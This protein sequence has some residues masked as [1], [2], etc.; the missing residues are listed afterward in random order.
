M[1]IES[2]NKVKEQQKQPLTTFILN[3]IYSFWMTNFENWIVVV[4]NP[5]NSVQLSIFLE[6]IPQEKWSA[7]TNGCK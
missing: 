2:N 7:T 6:I 1:L 5:K 3:D 4:K